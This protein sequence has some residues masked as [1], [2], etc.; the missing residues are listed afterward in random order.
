[1]PEYISPQNQEV[2]RLLGVGDPNQD[3]KNQVR[4][5]NPQFSQVDPSK[6]QGQLWKDFIINSLM[7][8]SAALGAKGPTSA[9]AMSPGHQIPKTGYLHNVTKTPVPPEEQ[10]I[11]NVNPPA[12]SNQSPN[13]IDWSNNPVSSNKYKPKAYNATTGQELIAASDQSS[14]PPAFGGQAPYSNVLGAQPGVLNAKNFPGINPNNVFIKSRDLA[15]RAQNN[16][17]DIVDTLMK[18]RGNFS[19]VDFEELPLEANRNPG[20]RHPN[21]GEPLMGPNASQT[22]Q[23]MT[24][25]ENQ[26]L[27]KLGFTESQIDRMSLK[28]RFEYLKD[29]GLYE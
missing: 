19:P 24:A 17:G 1:M 6:S 18:S 22:H 25:L 26:H 7:H 20:A 10:V 12:S 28:Q 15:P 13:F 16:L 2:L 27:Q 8:G 29:S 21:V 23:Y 14:S 4:G 9:T 5:L 3:L 11:P